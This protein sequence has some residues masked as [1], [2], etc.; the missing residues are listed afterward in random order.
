M[1]KTADYAIRL[2]EEYRKRHPEQSWDEAMKIIRSGEITEEL[3]DI[4]STVRKE[5]ED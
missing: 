4:I 1:S 3:E 2:G 5:K